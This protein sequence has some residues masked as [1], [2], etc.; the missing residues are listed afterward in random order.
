MRGL[1]IR[2]AYL[3]EAF[4]PFANSFGLSKLPDHGDVFLLSFVFFTF[5]HLVL[6]PT[7]SRWLFPTVFGKAERKA[8]NNW[9]IHIVSQLHTLIILPFAYPCLSL[10]NL[11]K[12]R[13]FGWDERA[14]TVQAIACG[15]FLWDTFDAIV[16][17]TDI[18]FVIHGLACLTIY[19]L[20]FKSFL[21]Y[22]AA[23]CLFWESSTFFLNIHWF[24]DKTG[25]T[26]STFQLINGI[27]LL[28]TFFCVRIVWGGYISYH[29]FHTL[30]DVRREIPWLYIP[31]YGLGNIALQ[32]LNWLW[33]GRMINALR[34]RFDG[35]PERLSKK[36]NGMNGNILNGANS[37]Y[38]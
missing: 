11:D 15:Y 4:I 27:F 31:I 28:L 16:N 1:D 33:F 3:R 37:K 6:A 21:A 18:G 23:R 36:S 8:R 9:S 22:Y 19:M 2:R 13:A 10:V 25:R 7:V 29:F 12:D 14:G 32:A 34:K 26:G 20:S 30:Y 24:L 38:E 5:V 17:Y 35:A